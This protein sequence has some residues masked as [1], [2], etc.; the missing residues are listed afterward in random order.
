MEE[1][2]CNS[3]KSTTYWQNILLHTLYNPAYWRSKSFFIV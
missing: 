1:L 3:N 2:A